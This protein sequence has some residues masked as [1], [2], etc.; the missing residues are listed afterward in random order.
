VRRKSDTPC[1]CVPVIKGAGPAA[2]IL[3]EISLAPKDDQKWLRDKLLQEALKDPRYLS[4]FAGAKN[5][6]LWL[7]KAGKLLRK[8]WL[9]LVRTARYLNV[10]QQTTIAHETIA[11]MCSDNQA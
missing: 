5:P 6:A 1:R 9:P 10:H 3:W 4:D 8:H 2:E 7:K 11:G